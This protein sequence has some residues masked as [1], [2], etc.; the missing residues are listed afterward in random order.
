MQTPQPGRYAI[1]TGTSTVRFRT[2]HMF[3]LG[4]VSGSFAIRRGT[5]EVAEPPSVQ[6]EIETASFRTGNAQRD[7]NVRSARL[8]DADRHPVMTFA[9]DGLGGRVLTGTLTVRGVAR[10]VALPVEL[11]EVSPGAFTVR[12]AMRVDRTVFGVTAYRGL[13][14]RHL[15]VSVEVQCVRSS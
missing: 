8:L 6:V 14:G 9:A 11:A 3:G 2:R 5:A 15:D 12:A 13:A 1:D 4:S 10:L 7:E